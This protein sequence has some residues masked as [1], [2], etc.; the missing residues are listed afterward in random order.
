MKNLNT[1]EEIK[2]IFP[3]GVKTGS[4]EGAS[5][6]LNYEGGWAFASQGVAVLLERVKK[7]GAVVYPG[8]S[9]VDLVKGEDGVTRGVK[10]ADG[11]S[12][13]ADLVVIA[14]GSW[15]PSTFPKLDLFDK[16]LAT[17]SVYSYYLVSSEVTL[18]VRV[19]SQV[20]A[21]IQLTPEEA[22]TYHNTPV[23]LSF[24]TGFYMF[25]VSKTRMVWKD[26]LIK[27]RSRTQTIS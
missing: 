18:T 6:Y 15:T 9:V 19:F 16:C 1:P 24:N 23:V 5:G 21:T 8:K 20:I 22:E 26:E 11:S 27:T 14:S 12:Y 13:D 25:P 7:L 10:T 4:F 3:P 2:A 17:G